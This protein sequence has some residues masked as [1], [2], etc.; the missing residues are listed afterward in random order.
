[1]ERDP[2]VRTFGS[3]QEYQHFPARPA[4]LNIVTLKVSM[5]VSRYRGVT[6]KNVRRLRRHF[7]AIDVRIEGAVEAFNLTNRTN[8]VT[9]NTN[10]GAGEYPT[11]PAPTYGQ[12]T[13]VGEPR[14]FQ[15][16]L[17]VRF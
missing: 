7:S 2:L 5:T 1:M 15:F 4:H 16:A 8:V 17:R 9:R 14:T 10:F 13:A 6:L 11:N 3:H 12:I